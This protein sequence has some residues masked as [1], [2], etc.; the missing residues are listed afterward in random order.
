[1]PAGSFPDVTTS[2][3]QV[4]VR[5]RSVAAQSLRLQDHSPPRLKGARSR[6]LAAL[7]RQTALRLAQHVVTLLGAEL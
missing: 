5:P 3:Q 2:G 7:V 4:S 1:M 6:L